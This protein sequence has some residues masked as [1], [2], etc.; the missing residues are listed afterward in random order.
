VQELTHAF[1]DMG[2]RVRASQQ[3]QREFVAN[4]SHELKTPLTSIQGF[5]Q[6]LEDGTADAPEARRQ[7]AGIIRQEAERMHR[8]VLDLLDLARFDSGMM[9]FQRTALDLPALLRNVTERLTPQAQAA[10]VTLELQTGDLPAIVG[11]GDR[12]VQVFS[13]LVDNAIKFT[14]SGGRV[15]LQAAALPNG[16][17][18][19]VSDT[20]AGMTPEVAAHI[21]ERFYQADASRRGGGKHGAGLGLAIVQEIVRA[22]GGR[23]SVRSAP[24][25]GSTFTVSLPLT[26]PAAGDSLSKRKK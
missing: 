9:D 3:S 19:E 26:P 24:G 20:G 14:P 7:A 5:A 12:L 25:A 23:I 8:M 16:V 4:V 13:N 2:A 22:H 6:A 15:G 18:V 11:D 17:Q 21:F 10:G 1:N